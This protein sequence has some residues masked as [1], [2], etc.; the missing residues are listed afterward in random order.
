MSAITI[1][2]LNSTSNANKPAGTARLV[3]V[4]GAL[5]A[6]AAIQRELLRVS[7]NI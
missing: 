5:I 3:Q 1:D 7:Q 6:P 4:L 2:A